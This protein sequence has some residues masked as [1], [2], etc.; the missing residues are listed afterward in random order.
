MTNPNELDNKS[1][2][3]FSQRIRNTRR[4]LRT[5]DQ[6]VNSYIAADPDAALVQTRQ[7]ANQ[8]R[9]AEAIL[10]RHIAA[11]GGRQGSDSNDD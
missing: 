5:A 1:R 8:L 10:E 11:A 4:M 6:L 9:E 7:A 2:G 3:I